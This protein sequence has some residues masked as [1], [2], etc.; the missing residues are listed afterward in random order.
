M[1]IKSGK[2]FGDGDLNNLERLLEI[3]DSELSSL[4]EAILKSADPDSAGLF[5]K[6]EY[7]VGVALTAIQQYMA[8]TFAQFRIEKSEALRLPPHVN[9]SLSFAAALNAVANFWK[10]RD[11]W[12]IRANVARDTESLC[13]Q[14]RQTIKTIE[15]LTP[16][17]DYTLSNLL[18]TLTASGELRL[19]ELVSRLTQW[20]EAVDSLNR[21]VS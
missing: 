5:D 17:D 7:F 8:S 9:K 2:S 11:E 13:P 1:Y 3:I 12:G 14:A 4:S 16:W 6:G 15:L 18:A 21:E 20:R 19:L 10:H